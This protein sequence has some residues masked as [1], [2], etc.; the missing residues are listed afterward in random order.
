MAIGLVLS[1]FIGLALGLFGGGGSILAVPIL[2]HVLGMQPRA[3][4]A[5][6]LLIVG[7]ASTAALI[8]HLRCGRIAIR[9]GLLF[10]S[11]AMVGAYIGGR[12]AR[13]VPDPVLLLGFGIMMVVTALAMLR[14]KKS[15]PG[16]A[17]PDEGRRS[18]I[19]L[20]GFGVG[21]IAGLIGAGGGFLIVP[22]LVL[23]GGMAMKR[24]VATSLMVIAMQS[25]AG[26]L[27]HLDH[28]AIPW[29]IVG[30]VTVLSAVGSIAGSTLVKAVRPESL[31]RGFAWLVLLV[32]ILFLAGQLPEVAR[33]SPAYLALFVM[34]WPWWVGGAAI[35]AV[36]LGLLFVENKQ[37]GVSTG[38][39]EVCRLPFHRAARASW[40]PRFLGGIVLGGALATVLAGGAPT[41][42]MGGFDQLVHGSGLKLA[43]LFGS[44]L[45]IGAGARLAGG[46]TS[47]HGIVGTALGARSSWLATGL[48]MV[49]GFATT[50][51]LLLMN[52]GL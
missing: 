25:F 49:G 48:F 13:F 27:G 16:E 43:V 1:V 29:E 26:F 4:I 3:A 33:K 37:L 35:A 22:A 10:G 15:S 34:R 38:C 32:A 19:L 24:A 12:A 52:G 51:L 45:L 17:A 20:H 5:G 21:T 31:R 23:F 14:Q 6:S 2:T 41:F 42:G 30:P 36:V 28:V 18:S 47:G 8:P 46:C 9:T 11:A 50:H 44:G 39:G 40:R 7:A